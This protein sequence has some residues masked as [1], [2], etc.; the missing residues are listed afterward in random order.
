M[1]DELA[2]LW[3]LMCAIAMWFPKRYLPRTF[4]KDRCVDL[5]ETASERL[6]P[7]R[8]EAV[9]QYNINYLVCVFSICLC[10]QEWDCTFK[11][12]HLIFQRNTQCCWRADSS[13]LPLLVTLQSCRWALCLIIGASKIADTRKNTASHVF[14]SLSI[15]TEPSCQRF[16]FV[17]VPVNRR[18]L[19]PQTVWWGLGFFFLNVFSCFCSSIQVKVQS[20]HWHPVRNHHWPGL[21]Q[22]CGQLTVINDTWHPLHCPAYYWA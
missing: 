2:I 3:V 9:L 15:V 6:F 14:T 1:L 13:S 21:R 19:P 16:S 12:L 5:H 11:S 4:R 18:L 20:G 7:Q 22:T 17:F 8:L 10:I